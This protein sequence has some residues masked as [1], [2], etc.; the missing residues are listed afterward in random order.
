MTSPVARRVQ[1]AFSRAAGSYDAAA[2]I[3]RQVVDE[4]ML[5]LPADLAPATIVD[6]G[7][8][9]GY[10]FAGLASRYPDACLIGLDFAESMLR[11]VPD[12]PRLQKIAGNAT[13]LPI[14]DATAD[15]VISSLT[16][17]WCAL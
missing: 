16:Y 3:Q 13:A 8:G 1:R 17:Q 11:R 9:T 12:R 4:L 2:E 15:L 7:C 5:R 10:A 6:L 14:A